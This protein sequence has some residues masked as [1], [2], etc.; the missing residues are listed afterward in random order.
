MFKATA[1]GEKGMIKQKG[2]TINSCCQI[3]AWFLGGGSFPIALVQVIS[4][5]NCL[6]FLAEIGGNNST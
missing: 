1:D 4:L 6:D 3:S 2:Y 5:R